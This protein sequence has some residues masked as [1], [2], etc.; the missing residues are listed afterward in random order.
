MNACSPSALL[1]Y[2]S[3]QSKITH[4]RVYDNNNSCVIKTSL[5]CKMEKNYFFT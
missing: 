2:L 1:N 5:I 4:S 3:N